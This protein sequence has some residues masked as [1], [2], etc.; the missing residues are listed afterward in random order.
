[1]AFG[2]C[3]SRGIGPVDFSAAPPV[4]FCLSSAGACFRSSAGVFSFAVVRAAPALRFSSGAL[5]G[6]AGLAFALVPVAEPLPSP[7][8]R[9]VDSLARVLRLAPPVFFSFV[10]AAFSAPGAS[11]LPSAVRRFCCGRSV[12]VPLARPLPVVR[13]SSTAFSWVSAASPGS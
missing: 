13:R 6:S 10:P 2:A 4:S 8:A 3:G 7:D 5:V 9:S 12:V 11:P 1:V